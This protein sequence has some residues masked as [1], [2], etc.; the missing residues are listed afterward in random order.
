MSGLLADEIQ[1]TA[2]FESAEVEAVLN[3][4]R[5]TDRLRRE[6][7]DL[8]KPFGL[9][10]TSF[11]VLRILRGAGDAGRACQD[12][13]S[14]LVAHDPDVT[15]L[16]DHLAEAGLLTRDRKP[17]DRRVVVLRITQA[18]LDLLAQ[19]DPQ[20]LALHRRQLG[21][22]GPDGLATLISLLERARHPA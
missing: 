14:R 17:G 12:V 2:P 8:L 6:A 22:L 18:G 19:L 16:A 13:A 11:N 3:L 21:H 20:L 7:N 9:T 15:R 4:V 5:T 10:S 1:M